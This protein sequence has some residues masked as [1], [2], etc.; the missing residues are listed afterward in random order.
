[1]VIVYA[2]LALIGAVGTWFFNI[3][4]FRAGEDYLAGWFANSA[5]SSAAVDV[6]VV[7]AVACYFMVVEARRLRMNLGVTGLLVALSFLVAIAF[8]FPAFLPGAPGTWT[9]IQ[10]GI[11]T[12]VQTGVQTGRLGRRSRRETT[13]ARGPGSPS[14]VDGQPGADDPLLRQRRAADE[15]PGDGSDG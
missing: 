14:R 3:A 10:T 6:I 5:S 7:A 11:Q 15:R 8:A 2:V 4:S 1:M 9:G 13:A 12:G